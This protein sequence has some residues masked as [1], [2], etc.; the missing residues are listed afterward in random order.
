MN[1]NRI[2]QMELRLNAKAAH[3]TRQAGQKRRQRAQW[4]FGQ[5]RRVVNAAMEWRPCPPPKPEQVYLGLSP[6]E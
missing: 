1:I 3:R 6:D 2:D 5:M 4:W